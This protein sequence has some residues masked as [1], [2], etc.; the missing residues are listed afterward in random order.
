MDWLHI[1]PSHRM[2]HGG[3]SRISTVPVNVSISAR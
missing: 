3:H 2:L 1:L